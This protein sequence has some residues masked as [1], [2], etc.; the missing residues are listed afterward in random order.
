MTHGVVPV[1]IEWVL[2]VVK[3]A[4]VGGVTFRV[5]GDGRG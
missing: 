5:L 3:A 2:E 1:V 4:V